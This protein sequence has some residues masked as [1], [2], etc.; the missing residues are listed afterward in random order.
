LKFDKRFQ[1]MY[2]HYMKTCTICGED[3]DFDS[4]AFRNKAQGTRRSQ[5]KSCMSDR[6][7]DSYKNNQARRDSI[8][9]NDSRRRQELIN[10]V[11]LHK[12]NHPCVDCGFSDPRAL[13]FDHLPEFEKS[14]DISAMVDR[15][16]AWDKIQEEMA[17][18]E[19][20]CAN[21]HR[22]RTHD[23]DSRRIRLNP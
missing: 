21:C 10:K 5:C 7:K 18:C 11:W 1:P 23:R 22:I 6:D 4:F 15:R 9:S 14:Y 19:V 20:V 3:K 2:T 17:K 16:F 12:I 13:E 8:K